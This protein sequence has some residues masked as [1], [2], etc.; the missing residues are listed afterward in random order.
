[1]HYF[2]DEEYT[3]EKGYEVRNLLRSYGLDI[4]SFKKEK[5]LLRWSEDTD[6]MLFPF[7]GGLTEFRVRLGTV[8]TLQD[9]EEWY[10]TLDLKEYKEDTLRFRND[11]TPYEESDFLE[12]LEIAQNE[13]TIEDDD[14][15]EFS[16]FLEDEDDKSILELKYSDP[17]KYED[18][19]SYCAGKGYEYYVSILSNFSGG[20]HGF[21]SDGPFFDEID[22]FKTLLKEQYIEINNDNIE[23]IK[24]M[25]YRLYKD[26]KVMMD[27]SGVL[28]KGSYEGFIRELDEL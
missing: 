25:S 5:F 19:L 9:M 15:P 14:C 1:M 6:D 4:H 7:E 17:E 10:G 23:K 16:I 24:E 11:F 2:E 21:S 28:K 8:Y 27:L 26:G 18:F 13:G 22:E 12:K 3:I 20:I